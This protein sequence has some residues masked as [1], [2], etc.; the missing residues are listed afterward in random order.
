VLEQEGA[1][2]ALQAAHDQLDGDVAGRALLGDG[3]DRLGHARAGEVARE[4]LDDP[5]AAELE[6]LRYLG[7][8]IEWRRFVGVHGEA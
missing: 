7:V 6:P 8:L 3:H 5:G 2:P 4:G 1:L